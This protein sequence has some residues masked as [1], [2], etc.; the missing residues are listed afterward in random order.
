MPSRREITGFRR[1][2][3]EILQRG[4]GACQL[5]GEMGLVPAE[6]LRELVL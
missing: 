5:A 6:L 1:F 4:E 2:A 3:L